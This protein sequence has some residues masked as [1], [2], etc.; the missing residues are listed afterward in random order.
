MSLLIFFVI[1]ADICSQ[2]V[3]VKLTMGAQTGPGVTSRNVIAEIVG[4][5]KPHEVVVMGGHI[6]AYS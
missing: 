5:E 3:T 1:F 2:K 4:R 6:G